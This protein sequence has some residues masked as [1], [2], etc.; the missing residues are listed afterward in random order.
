[1][2]Y[3]RYT[4]VKAFEVWLQWDRN[5]Y[6]AKTYALPAMYASSLRTVCLETSCIYVYQAKYPCVC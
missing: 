2:A 5:I 3:V 4:P 6:N 1:M